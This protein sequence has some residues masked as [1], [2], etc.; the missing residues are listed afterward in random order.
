MAPYNTG[1]LC[2]WK[3]YSLLFFSIEVFSEWSWFIMWSSRVL[4]KNERIQV[5]LIFQLSSIEVRKD[6]RSSHENDGSLLRWK[7][8]CH[9]LQGF[10]S[11][12]EEPCWGLQV[13]QQIEVRC[14]T[15][16]ILWF[17]CGSQAKNV[18]EKSV[19]KFK[20]LVSEFNCH[21]VNSKFLGRI[22]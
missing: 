8:Y 14:R 7:T 13:V 19:F 15:L 4:M 6:S 17:D 9:N 3:Q 1:D 12:F 20:K 5:N 22:H 16:K 2:E 10:P 18:S 11:D 21:L